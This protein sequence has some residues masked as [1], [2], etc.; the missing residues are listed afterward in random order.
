MRKLR[1]RTVGTCPF[2]GLQWA[3]PL[4]LGPVWRTPTQPYAACAEAEGGLGC[5]EPARDRQ[6]APYPARPWVLALAHVAE[7]GRSGWEARGEERG[8]SPGGSRS[9]LLFWWGRHQLPTWHG[10]RAACLVLAVGRSVSSSH[11]RLGPTRPLTDLQRCPSEDVLPPAW[12]LGVAVA[13]RCELAFP[14]PHSSSG[15]GLK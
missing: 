9:S 2:G 13:Q 5:P 12:V 3:Q 1:L 6:K 8:Q 10:S 7:P 4:L 11:P 14:G 15:E